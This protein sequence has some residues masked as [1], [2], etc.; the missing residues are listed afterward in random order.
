MSASSKPL[1]AHIYNPDNQTREQL[2]DSFV[3]RVKKFQRIYE[4]I[5]VTPERFPLQHYVIEGKRGMGKTTF[6]LRLAYEIEGDPDLR[7][8]LLP[9]VFNEE[10]YSIRKL[11]RLWERIAKLLEEKDSAFTGLFDEMDRQFERH[12][13]EDAYEEAIFKLLTQRLQAHGKKIILFIDNF[14][15]IFSRFT[16]H[17]NQRLRT[18]LQTST[19]L[20]I[21]AA[22]A[23]VLEVFFEYKHPFYD[24]F[25]VIRLPGLTREENEALLLKLG[26]TYKQEQIKDILANQP[27]RVEALRRLTG[28]VIRTVVLLFEIFTDKQQGSAFDD[29]EAILDR[30]SPLYKH[31]MDD[32]PPEQ[33]DIANAVALGWDAMTADEIARSTRLPLDV[34]NKQLDSLIKNEILERT[35]NP[36]GQHLY[37]VSER[38]FNIWYLMRHGRKGDKRRVLW[39]VRFLEEWCDEVGIVKRANEHIQA[40]KDGTYDVRGA[41][42]LSEAIAGTK[43]I[44][45]KKKYQLLKA[46]IEYLNEKDKTLADFLRKNYEGFLAELEKTE[47]KKWD[48]S[49]ILDFAGKLT[50]NVSGVFFFELGVLMNNRGNYQKAKHFY[51]K[52]AERAY[53]PAMFDLAFL[54]Q[55]KFKNYRKAEI[56]Y[57]QA[58][59]N[60]INR[61]ISNLGYLYQTILLDF[62]KAE[63]FYLQAIGNGDTIAMINLANLYKDEFENYPKAEQLY[64]QAINKGET[65]AINYLAVFY[66][67]QLKNYQKAE[68]FYLKAIEKED[69]D[70]FF[71]LAVL[72]DYTFNDLQKAEKFYGKAAENGDA[73][74]MNNLANIFME[75]LKVYDRAE[76]L[77]LQAS[78]KGDSKSLNNLSVLY[79]TKF[80]N[81]NKAEQYYQ[82]ALEKGTYYNEVEPT[83]IHDC[84][85]FLLSRSHYPLLYR[86]F[87][88]PEAESVHLKDRLKPL[89]YALMYY[90]QDEHPNEYLRM[91]EELRETVQEIIAEVEEMRKRYE[92][93]SKD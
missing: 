8:W 62:Q 54:Y 19:D 66:H 82:R 79:A 33:A 24:F 3:V 89:W 32:L 38:F 50:D 59:E 9:L 29:L 90:M 55:T 41:Y 25:K 39:L 1:V 23:V 84:F 20:Q 63:H 28:G 57:L 69:V 35:L 6:L 16:L 88:S 14:G 26:E 52:A 80:K 10:E 13:S 77:Y 68:E 40:M 81:Y 56:Y 64:L 91:G 17:E 7:D 11:F 48:F 15:D 83:P 4:E 61:A 60:G 74:A 22:S 34:V 75:K 67:N 27:G 51:I 86:H 78:K 47:T 71:N 42:Y 12:P 37:L 44:H 58:I 72:Y 65:R 93:A 21:I 85:K 70:A 92:P 5:K 49:R 46:S 36:N 53:P 43:H 45:P 87:T 2:I 76:Q 31:R 73:K 30:V 18:I